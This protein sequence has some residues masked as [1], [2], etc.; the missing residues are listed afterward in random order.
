MI[1]LG[2]K[3]I[4]IFKK[5]Y[6]HPFITHKQA[7]KQL[8]LDRQ[9]YAISV[10][11]YL[12]IEVKIYGDIPKQNHKLYAINH[13]SLLDIIVMESIFSQHNKSGLW[14]AK[15]ELF[16]AFYGKFF[17]Y[18][19]N[20]SVDVHNKTGLISFF[21]KIKSA[22]LKDNDLNIYIFPEGERNRTNRL[23]KFQSGASKISKANRLDIIPV[24]INDTLEIVLKQ[25]PFKKK[26][27]IE[28]YFGDIVQHNELEEK[29]KNFTDR[30]ING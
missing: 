4:K 29:Y 14:I 1:R 17:K 20:I 8:S 9:N 18:S 12:N 21:K 30:I 13:R 22:L 7:H 11:N 24:Y 23:L 28:V 10:L 3:Y 2:Y 15:E 19:A 25:A 5:T 26:K 16:K 6:H 27:T